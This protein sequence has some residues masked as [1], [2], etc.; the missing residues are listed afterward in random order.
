MSYNPPPLPGECMMMVSGRS[1]LRPGER[2]WLA[3][4]FDV[5]YGRDVLATCNAD[6][7]QCAFDL[8]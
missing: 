6:W 3:G 7:G 1:L 2:F 5:M 8:P 4:R